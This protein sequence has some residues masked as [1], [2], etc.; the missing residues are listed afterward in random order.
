[1]NGIIES[2][3][4]GYGGSG[5][6][7]TDN[8]ADT[9]ISWR[10]QAQANAAA[11][12][13][14]R[15]AHG[16]TSARSA[17]IR[18]ND[19]TVAELNVELAPTGAWTT[20]QEVSVDASLI[21]GPNVIELISNSIDGLANIDSLA[22]TGV[23]VSAQNCFTAFAETG[24][25]GIHDPATMMKENGVYWTFGTGAR[26][27]DIGLLLGI[28]SRFSY[29]LKHWHAGPSLYSN[30]NY[31]SWVDEKVTNMDGVFWAPDVIHMNGRYYMY[32]SAYA[33]LNNGGDWAE[34]TIGLM[35]TDSLNNPNWQ[36]LGVVVD[37]TTHVRPANGAFVNCI[38]AGLY[39]D[40]NNNVWMTY[41][42]H[43]GGIWTLQIN[44]STGM[45][46]N[47]TR[48]PIAGVGSA[49]LWTE[50]EGAQIQFINGYYYLFVNLGDCC[51]LLD[52]DYLIVVGRS[53]NPNGPFV[54][55][56]GADLYGADLIS[57]DDIDS[58]VT[59]GST[60]ASDGKYIGPG[61]FGY[62]N[63]YGQNLASIHYYDGNSN[64]YPRL[65][66]L[67]LNFTSDGWPTFSHDFSFIEEPVVTT[68]REV[69]PNGAV[70]HLVPYHAQGQAI[71][72]AS[73]DTT[74][75]TNVGQWENFQNECQAWHFIETDS[76]Y[77]RL[78]PYPSYTL[79]STMEVLDA[80]T[81]D[82]ANIQVWGYT[83]GTHQQYALEFNDNGSATIK[84]RHSGKCLTIEGASTASGANLIQS[85]CTGASNQQFLLQ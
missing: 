34:S 1:M 8:A 26:N 31:P 18:I 32:Y 70:F 60:L 54:A 47:S 80:S 73:C 61:H 64:G 15:Y 83:G 9:R 40:K 51:A 68:P 53:A 13:T 79:S 30:G 33:V 3:H 84:L 44:P 28:T 19:G 38:D 4:A 25:N 72:L 65:N 23:S 81:A 50:Y 5:Y 85:T 52:S 39:R 59:A 57:Q 14:I 16:G 82:G 67:K 66:I 43:F 6:A 21:Q 49:G 71:D 45:P 58:G 55:Q 7:N 27:D 29:D 10:V 48:Y 74:N 46:L 11:S 35:V 2:E 63:N 20:W 41:G 56:S 22:I 12:F 69:L 76:G 17:T 37:S 62:I 77:Y 42:S 24:E 75:G 36:D 78:V